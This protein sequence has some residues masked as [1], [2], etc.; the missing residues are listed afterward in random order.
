MKKRMERAR[1][2]A[3]KDFPKLHPLQPI[4]ERIHTILEDA[5]AYRGDLHRLL[6]MWQE[7]RMQTFAPEI[8]VKERLN[9][10]FLLTKIVEIENLI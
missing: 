8:G 1:Y 3:G 9:E 10:G 7:F 5:D 2:S 6:R 4:S